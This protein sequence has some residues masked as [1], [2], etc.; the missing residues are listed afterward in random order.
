MKHSLSWH[1]DIGDE[2]R[3]GYRNVT[4]A[5]LDEAECKSVPPKIRSY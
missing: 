5:T 3:I 2:I 4:M 1:K